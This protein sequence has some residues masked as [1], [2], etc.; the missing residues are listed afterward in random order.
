MGR[1]GART[2]VVMLALTVAAMAGCGTLN[3]MKNT[4]VTVQFSGQDMLHLAIIPRTLPDGTPAAKQR[5]ALLKDVADVAGGYT[6]VPS[7]MSAW[8]PKGS[9]KAAV[10][11]PTTCCWW[12]ARRCW[13]R[14]CDRGCTTTSASPRPSC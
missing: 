1:L 6:L 14:A 12:K 3:T 9:A 8:K 10:K 2:M 7:V 11:S 4:Y 5:D 13:A